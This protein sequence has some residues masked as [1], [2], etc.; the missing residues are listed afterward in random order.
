ML[1]R[2]LSRYE[3]LWNEPT[4]EAAVAEGSM[5]VQLGDGPW[6]EALSSTETLHTTAAPRPLSR[7]LFIAVS[8]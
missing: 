1:L 2:T 3:T 8:D 5:R 7:V 6:F 4:A